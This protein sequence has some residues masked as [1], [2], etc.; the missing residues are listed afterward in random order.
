MLV[1]VVSA[2]IGAFAGV[3]ATRFAGH[4]PVGD[5]RDRRRSRIAKKKLTGALL[6]DRWDWR[7]LKTL[8]RV[9]GTT[10]EQQVRDWLME[11][12]A[13]QSGDGQPIWTLKMREEIV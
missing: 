1:A 7:S 3:V 12:G 8:C 6:D 10:D 11:I 4:I 9:A 5:L 13:R 2:V